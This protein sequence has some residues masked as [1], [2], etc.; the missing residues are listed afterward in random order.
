LNDVA[1]TRVAEIGEL[2][3]KDDLIEQAFVVIEEVLGQNQ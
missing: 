3:A 2:D 1:D